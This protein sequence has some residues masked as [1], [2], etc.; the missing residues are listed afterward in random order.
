MNCF[1]TIDAK[2]LLSRLGGNPDCSMDPVS[3]DGTGSMLN[4]FAQLIGFQAVLRNDV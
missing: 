1:G 4:S 2:S 3:G